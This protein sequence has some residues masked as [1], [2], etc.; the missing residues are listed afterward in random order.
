VCVYTTASIAPFA[1]TLFI[2][3]LASRQLERM[4]GAYRGKRC[5]RAPS[6]R[7][8]AR[9]F[10]GVLNLFVSFASSQARWNMA[11]AT[12]LSS[13]C[14]SPPPPPSR[15]SP[16]LSLSKMPSSSPPD[17]LATPGGGQHMRWMTGA[18]QETPPPTTLG[19]PRERGCPLQPQKHGR[20]CRTSSTLQHHSP[21]GGPGNCDLQLHCGWHRW[22]LGWGK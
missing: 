8:F 4:A 6:H 5:C 7:R 13:S 16:S 10:F 17:P 20:S 12:V 11:K 15:P 1:P 2:F 3:L 19:A 18:S 22:I 14:L 9:R 21:G